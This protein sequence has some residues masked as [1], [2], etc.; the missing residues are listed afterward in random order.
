MS[1]SATANFVPV[2]TVMPDY[3]NAPFLW[4]VDRS[5]EGGV[6]GCLCDGTYWDKSFPISEG[7]WRM[8]ADWAIAFDKTESTRTS[9][10]SCWD[11]TRFHTRGLQLARLLKEEVGDS[12]RVVYEKPF[13]DPDHNT[14]ER[15]EILADGSLAQYIRA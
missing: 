4:R 1:D 13:E 12:Y 9:Y 8:F 7:L 10:A 11:W 5:N 3:G 6:G 2:L 14:D 15:T